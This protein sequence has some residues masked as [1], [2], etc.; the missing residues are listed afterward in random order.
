MVA[1]A[2]AVGAQLRLAR[3]RRDF[4]ALAGDGSTD[5]ARVAATQNHRIDRIGTEVVQSTMFYPADSSLEDQ[6]QQQQQ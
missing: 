2:L 5:I 6:Q 1:L 4:V 3:I